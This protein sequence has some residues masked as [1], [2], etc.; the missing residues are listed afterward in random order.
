MLGKGLCA[1]CV[2]T[3]ADR[4]DLMPNASDFNPAA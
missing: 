1:V 4:I 2:L 3:T